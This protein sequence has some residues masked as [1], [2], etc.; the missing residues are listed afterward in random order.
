MIKTFQILF[1][2][3]LLLAPPSGA[4]LAGEEES[5]SKQQIEEIIRNYI[6]E[7]PEI[8]TQAVLILREREE[9]RT[10]EAVQMALADNHDLLFND[11]LSIVVGNP[12]G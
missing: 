9:Q 6:L 5:L 7:N 2:A 4:A 11:E 3:V 12:E 1:A 10:R 8:I